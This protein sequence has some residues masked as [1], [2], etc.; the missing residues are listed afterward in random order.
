LATPPGGGARAQ[1]RCFLVSSRIRRD[2]NLLVRLAF[3]AV[4]RFVWW[5]IPVF[6][7]IGN[8]IFF[9]SLGN[10]PRLPPC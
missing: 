4:T 1:E 10:Q 5:G 8:F 2:F 3:P 9:G 7:V 6:C